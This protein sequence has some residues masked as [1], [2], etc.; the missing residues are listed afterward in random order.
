MIKVGIIGASGYTGLELLRILAKHSHIQ[1]VLA[2]SETYAGKKAEH[3]SLTL[4]KLNDNEVGET[5]DLVFCCLPHKEA[6]AH[7]PAWLKKG[8][9]VVDLSA[10]FRFDSASLY[11]EWYQKHEA[12]DLLKQAVYGLPEFYREKIKKATLVG[13]PGCYP[14]GA[15][16]GILPLLKAKVILPDGIIIDSK[17]GMSGAGRKAVEE[18]LKESAKESVS[19][20]QVGHHRHTPEID[21]EISKMAGKEVCV[22]FTPHLMPMHRGILSTIYAQPTQ[23]TDL[24]SIYKLF[25]EAYKDEPFIQV[26]KPG[27]WPRTKEV[28]G[29]NNA[30]I[31]AHVDHRI[32]NI[33]I[34]TAIDNLMKGASGQ[35]VQNMNL[36]CGFEETAGL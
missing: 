18:D 33:V 14:T 7:V 20:Y 21:Q 4:K 34:M 3:T 19:A 26:L 22:N 25:K 32:G 8:V 27:N 35:A 6:M 30:L 28:T 13:N 23:K 12:P 29:T 31:S 15:L 9:K 11:E 24:P 17:S 16:L 36:M 2:T 1:I 5:C 10:D